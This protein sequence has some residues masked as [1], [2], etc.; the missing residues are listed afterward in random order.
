VT[1]WVWKKVT[2]RFVTCV[3]RICC[4]LLAQNTCPGFKVAPMRVVDSREGDKIS[5][6]PEA[7]G[8]ADTDSMVWG[9]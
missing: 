2:K 6:E 3:L 7:L 4:C 9:G 1:S 5:G 8:F